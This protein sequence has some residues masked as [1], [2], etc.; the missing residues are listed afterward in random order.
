MATKKRVG[1]AK[2]ASSGKYSPPAP[3]KPI[4][5]VLE[6]FVD[7]LDP[8]HIYI[9]HIDSKPAEFKRKIFM[10]PIF[11]NFAVVLAF[12]WRMWSILPWY[13][14]IAMTGLGH[15][16]KTSFPFSEST[17]KEFGY[18]ICKRGFTMFIDFL[19]LVFVWPWPVEF[20]AGM[21]HG[22]PTKWRWNVGFRD[23]EIYVRRSRDWDK[24]LGDIFKDE[25]SHRIFVAYVEQATSPLLQ[26]QK[27]GYL[28][29]SGQ[30]DLDWDSM[31]SAHAMVDKKDAAIEAFKN[32]VLMHNDDFGWL[33]YNL[34][35]GASATEE[36]KRRQVFTFRDALVGMGKENLFYRWVEIVQFEATRPGGFGEAQQAAAAKKIRELFEGENV[37]FDGLWKETVGTSGIG[38]W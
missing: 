20:V 33:T 31:V 19:L 21:A 10:V 34:K 3:F 5:D 27:T 6:D 15:T 32:V 30:W 8:T 11:M 28:L 7:D 25:D 26:E 4:P 13:G 14:Q 23:K 1:K 22:N 17:W 12:I 16:N 24:L 29:M 9:T 37:D 18:E 38:S 36:E 2:E 35:E